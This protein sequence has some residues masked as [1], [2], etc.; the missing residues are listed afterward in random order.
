M[1]LC[2]LAPADSIHSK[3]WTEYFAKQGH[4]VYWL[5]FGVGGDEIPEGIKFYLIK[6]FPL[7]PLRP[8]SY[9]VNLRKILSKI[10]PDIFHVHQVW[11]AGIMGALVNFHPLVL[12]AWGSDVLLIPKSKLKKPLVK[13]ALR[14]ADLITCDAWHVQEAMIKLGASSQKIKIVCFGI[15]TKK[16][17]PD[18]EDENL[19]RELKIQNC[20]IVISLRSFKS[21]YD[22]ET[23][24]RAIP[25][26]L[27]EFPRAKFIIV[28]EG[29]EEDKIKN[30]AKDLGILD[31]TRFVG[32]VPNEEL[33]K[34]LRVSDVYVS[35]ALSDAGIAASTAEAMACCLP[36]VI[37]NTG[38]NE[39]WVKDRESGF[40]IPVK[41]PEILAEKI[42]YLLRDEN[43][44]KKFGNLARK[45]IIEENDYYKE[46][47][48]MEN[49]YKEILEKIHE[50]KTNFI[51]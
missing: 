45:K 39:R 36:V 23:L 46:M 29:P 26:V 31:N 32:S 44:R 4:E 7:R 43:K 49:L 21:I 47:A 42:V 22:I 14:R 1:R 25:P 30:L 35:T 34:Y 51:F 17:S 9:T 12:T 10:K 48:K 6:K 33:P 37:T 13:F 27:K 28:G 40:L 16:F 11:M 20:P 5:S 41:K 38:E 19:T 3:K 15:D 18:S 8:F 24:I 50:R 2:F